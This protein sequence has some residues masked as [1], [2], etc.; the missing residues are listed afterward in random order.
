MASATGW[1]PTGTVATTVLVL[2]SMTATVSA[3]ALA[4]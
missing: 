3:I 1:S 4:T 2:G